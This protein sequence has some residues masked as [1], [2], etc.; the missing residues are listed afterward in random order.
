MNGTEYAVIGGSLNKRNFKKAKLDIK[1]KRRSSVKKNYQQRRVWHCTL[2]PPPT[3]LDPIM[4]KVK[5][6]EINKGSSSTKQGNYIR[7]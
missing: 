6:E 2:I 3:L 5:W 7:F 1:F 4:M